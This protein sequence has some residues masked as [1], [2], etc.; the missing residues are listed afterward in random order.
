MK[1]LQHTTRDSLIK[2]RCST[3]AVGNPRHQSI[4]TS[5]SVDARLHRATSANVWPKQALI[6]Y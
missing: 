3:A 4:S 6:S 2:M 1:T 5:A